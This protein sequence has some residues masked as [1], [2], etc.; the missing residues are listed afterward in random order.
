[1]S[2]RRQFIQTGLSAVMLGLMRR[3]SLAGLP[4][5]P[6]NRLLQLVP[7][8]DPLDL[9]RPLIAIPESLQ[10]VRVQGLPFAP[11]FFGDDFANHNVVPFH[12]AENEYPGGEPPPSSEVVD[13]AIIGGGM[14][15]LASAY[16]LRDLHPVLFELHPRFGGVSQ[17]ESWAGTDYSHGGAYFITPDDGTYLAD[18]YHELGLGHAHRLNEGENPIEL[19][20][21][22]HNDFFTGAGLSPREIEAFQRYAHWV[23]Y[24]GENYPDIPF[25]NTLGNEWIL[26]LDKLSFREDVEQR[27]GMPAPPLLAAGIQSYFYSSFNAGWEEISAASG[28]NFVAAEEFGRWVCPGGNA[29]VADVFWDRLRKAYRHAQQGDLSSRLRPGCRAVEVRVD[30]AGQSP[31]QDTA[32]V[33]VIW[34]DAQGQFHTLRA[35]HVIMANSKRIAKYM[36]KDLQAL[37]PELQIAM[38]AVTTNAYVVAN[39]LLNAPLAT[40]NYDIFLLGDGI[41]YPTTAGDVATH[42]RVV[43]ALSGHYAR[44]SHLPRSVLTLYWPLPWPDGV[45]PLLIDGSW[46]DFANRLAALIDPIL[47]LVGL[48]RDTVKQVRMTR[49][50]HAMPIGY[51]GFL[52]N[53]APQVFRRGFMDCVWFA[54][55]DNWA[56]PAF[57]TAILEAQFCCDQLRGI[58]NA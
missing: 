10:S 21:V 36:I 34:K 49:W 6:L 26:E 40:D 25:N 22:I 33:H 16:F 54:N 53:G 32:R 18:L 3:T 31:D 29:Y 43:D 13:I 51:P 27:I 44:R 56:L 46:D 47:N 7:S 55:Q 57:E 42:S 37:D 1:M 39:V 23:Q 45:F 15:G 38:S 4:A 2:T 24:F 48:T 50:G 20:G 58:L 14:T 12:H 11:G 28:W 5:N 35:R 41:S 19:N 17:G 52:A 9:S 30:P 8:I